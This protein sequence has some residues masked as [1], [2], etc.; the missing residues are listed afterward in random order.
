MDEVNIAVISPQMYPCITGGVEIFEYYLI[1]ELSAQGHK[2]WVITCCDYNWNNRNI[3]LVK[4]WKGYPGLAFLSINF[5][6]ILNLNKVKGKIDLVHVPYTSNSN[7]AYSALLVKKLFD[8][9][10]I[11]T[12]HGGGMYE[13]KP[14]MPHQLF[15]KYANALVAVSETIKKEYELRTGRKI[16][17]IPPLLPFKEPEIPKSELKNK[18]G[19]SNNDVILLSV[20]SIK[21]IKGSDVLLDAFLSLETEYVKANNLKLLYVGDGVMRDDLEK[22]VNEKNFSSYVKFFGNIS[23]EKVPDMFKL[24]DI[25]VISSLF[26]GN[27]IALLEAMF[28]GLP[29]IGTNVNGVNDLISHGKNGLLF[30][31]GNVDD[32]KE[33]IKELVKNENLSNRLGN[34]AKNDYFRSCS[35]EDVVF[36][37]IK[38]C[39]NIVEGKQ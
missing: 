17:V 9:P 33:K 10:Y 34:A 15:F 7:L 19:F 4:L 25:Y 36:E 11:I 30:E 13:W 21:K 22:K 39:R 29:I 31:K 16:K 2:I 32:L 23:H 12:V 28:N 37:Y 3:H 18:L 27:P 14:K 35:F 5:S 24:A 26:E 8:I 6:M 20:G 38:L 1:K